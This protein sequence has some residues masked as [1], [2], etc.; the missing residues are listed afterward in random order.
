MNRSLRLK[1]IVSFL[2]VALISVVVIAVTIRLGSNDRLLSLVV[3]KQAAVI[4]EDALTYFRENGSWTGFFDYISTNNKPPDLFREI[5]PD[6][7]PPDVIV[8]DREQR[9]LVALVD[10]DNRLIFPA[11]GLKVGTILPP[12]LIQDKIPL[13]LDGETIAYLIP[14]RNLK[15]KLSAEEE[16]FLERTNNMILMA[17][18]IGAVG[19]ILMGILLSGLLLKPIRN[20]MQASQAMAAGDLD[21]Q[22]PV[23]SKD[24]LGQLS[25]SFNKMSADLKYADEQRKQITADI[26][27]DLGTPL[28]VISGYMEMLEDDPQSL[29]PK[30]IETINTEIDHLRRM[31]EDLN[32]LSQADARVLGIQVEPIDPGILIEE[33]YQA[34]QPMMEKGGLKFKKDIQPQ[35]PLVP[36]DEGRMVQV[37]KN[38]VENAMRYTHKNGEITL[39]VWNENNQIVF[40]VQDNGD[41]ISA[42]D[43]PHI[44]DRFYRVESPRTNRG[45]K[46]GLGLTIS[47]ALVQAQGGEIYAFSNGLGMGTTMRIVFPTA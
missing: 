47:R 32:M 30:R 37:I 20:L 40:E 1:L 44:F 11:F 7:K 16:V 18:L 42:K 46:A 29:T 31:L 10:L 8:N 25:E 17:A 41:G 23:S 9:P 14:D 43:L 45:G 35:L 36:L 5:S 34:Y 26:T 12:N 33:I 39:R 24:E 28:Q 13:E 2:M 3:D 4:K 38:L 19:A 21:Q 15:F 22:V 6:N 27:H